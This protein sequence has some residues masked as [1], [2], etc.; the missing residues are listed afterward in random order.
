[1][2]RPAGGGDG[3]EANGRKRKQVSHSRPTLLA[4]EP[5]TAQA[6]DGE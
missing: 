4:V 6:E 1:M 5:S 3:D 2:A